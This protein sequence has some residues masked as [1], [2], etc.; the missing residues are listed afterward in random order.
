MC[1][2]RSESSPPIGTQ[3]AT[4]S[5]HDRSIRPEAFATRHANA[6]SVIAA[7]APV[8][9]HSA[10]VS[11]SSPG[12]HS[13]SPS[14]IAVAGADAMNSPRRTPR[15]HAETNA[16]GMGASVGSVDPNSPPWLRFEALPPLPP[17]L[18]DPSLLEG[19]DGGLSCDPPER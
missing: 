1:T 15:P 11:S 18:R 4:G 6:S 10:H 14:V 13:A 8:D 9:S 7:F 12:I 19:R 17:L 16:G 3:T 2:T 5:S